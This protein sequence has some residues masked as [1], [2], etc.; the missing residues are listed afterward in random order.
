MVALRS[1]EALSFSVNHTIASIREYETLKMTILCA[2]M[3]LT[4]GCSL[5]YRGTRVADPR[6][7]PHRTS[8][9]FALRII[10]GFDCSVLPDSGGYYTLRTEGE[11][12]QPN[13][14]ESLLEDL[15]SRGFEIG[16]AW[17]HPGGSC[18]PPGST[19]EGATIYR[20]F[21]IVHLEQL[22]DRLVQYFK[23][24]RIPRPKQFSCE[25]SVGEFYPVSR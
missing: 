17:Y 10:N 16:R 4:I 23:F 25:Y 8:P 3:C 15:Y 1:V 6:Y 5:T 12:A 2:T 13:N 18:R 9:Q 14:P 21:F 19:G 11:T 7:N 24:V 20:G 22:D